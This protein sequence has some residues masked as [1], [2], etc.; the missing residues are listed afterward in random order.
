MKT[1]FIAKIGFQVR[2]PS[3]FSDTGFYFRLVPYYLASKHMGLIKFKAGRPEGRTVRL[4]FNLHWNGKVLWL[5]PM[6]WN[7]FLFLSICVLSIS[8][9]S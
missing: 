1:G 9:N 3:D 2:H 6:E 4:G 8:F 7:S 5:R